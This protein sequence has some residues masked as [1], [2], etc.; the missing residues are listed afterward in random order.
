MATEVLDVVNSM[1]DFILKYAL[2]LAATSALAMALLEAWK[3]IVKSRE[4]FHM[5]CLYHWIS[6]APLPAPDVV[7]PAPNFHDRVYRQLILLTTGEKLDERYGLKDIERA[8]F[9]LS[10]S[11]AL[12]A[13]TEERM[14]GQVQEAADLVLSNPSVYPE[15]YAF[16]TEGASKDDIV[17]WQRESTQVPGEGADPQ[18]M[19]ARVDAFSRLTKFVKRRLDS[20]QIAMS[21]EW[22]SWNQWCS[23]VVGAT[24]LFVSLVYLQWS[25]SSSVA[26]SGT[27][28][29]IVLASLAG[30]MVAPVAKDLVTALRKVRS[31]G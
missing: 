18:K 25:D 27:W 5:R 4:R 6:A 20:L 17:V 29:R 14:L 15:F 16:L 7:P 31:G 19:K 9:E 28:F 1:T 23:I 10:P 30:G 24:L 2:A 21:Y 8:S 12:F 13:L 22:A 26:D 3:S 11:S